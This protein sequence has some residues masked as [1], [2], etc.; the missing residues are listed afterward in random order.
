MITRENFYLRNI[1]YIDTMKLE[2]ILDNDRDHIVSGETLMRMI[3]VCI[4]TEYSSRFSVCMLKDISERDWV[5][6]EGED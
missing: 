6:E 1:K 4:D 3:M 2:K 5:Y